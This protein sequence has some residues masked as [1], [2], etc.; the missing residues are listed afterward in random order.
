MAIILSFFSKPAGC[1]L[2]SDSHD[3]GVLVIPSAWTVEIFASNI[4][5]ALSKNN[6]FVIKSPYAMKYGW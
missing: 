3:L 6:P 1:P 5:A 4:E 2:N